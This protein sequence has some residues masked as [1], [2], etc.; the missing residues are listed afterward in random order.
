MSF[1]WFSVLLFLFFA[2]VVPTIIAWLFYRFGK[3]A[4]EKYQATIYPK[5]LSNKIKKEFIIFGMVL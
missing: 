4:S 5:K 1:K 2:F 3:Y